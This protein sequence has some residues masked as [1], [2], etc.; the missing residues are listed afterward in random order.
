MR[1]VL[2]NRAS[3]LDELLQALTAFDVSGYRETR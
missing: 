2:I 1:S 3:D